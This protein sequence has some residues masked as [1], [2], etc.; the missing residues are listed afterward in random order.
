MLISKDSQEGTLFMYFQFV[1]TNSGIIHKSK[2]TE[3]SIK[4]KLL[5]RNG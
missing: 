5:G 4:K 2:L 1:Q 3:K